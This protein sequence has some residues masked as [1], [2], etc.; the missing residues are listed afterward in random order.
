MFS[1]LLPTGHFVKIAWRSLLKNKSASIINL[2]GLS[3]G[4]TCCL[5]MVMYIQHEL[6]Y[7]RFQTKGERIA[8]VIMQ[9]SFGGSELT[10]G[11]FT[12]T[13]VLPSFKKNF[14]EVVDGVRLSAL[15]RLVKNKD[16]TFDEKGFLYADS[17]FFEMFDFKLIR[18]DAKTVLNGVNQIVLT[19]SAAKKYFGD[20]DP[21]GKTLQI[22]SSHENHIV[23]GI[24]ADCPANSQLIFTMVAPFTTLVKNPQEES[25]FEANYTTYLLLRDKNSIGTLQQK[26]EPFMKSELKNETGVYINYQFEPY[27]S[28][29]LHSPY[30]ALTP[31]SNIRYIYIIGA[32][33]I[34]V[35][36]IAC[37]TYINLSTAR[38]IERA[39]E[40]GI[41][42]VSGAVKS[43]VFWQFITESA[44]ISLL[45]T[46]VSMGLLIFVIPYFN[47]LTDKQLIFSDALKPGILAVAALIIAVISLLAG[48]YPA[49]ILSNYEPIKV[50]KGAFKNTSSGALLRK[51]LIVFQF[52]ISLFLIASTIVIGRQL[53]Y[54]QNK[55]LGYDR[56]HIILTKIDQKMRDKMDLFKTELKTNS[57]ITSVSMGNFTPVHIPGGYVMYRGDQTSDQAINTRGNNID[58]DYIKTNGLNII[59]GTDLT[60]QDLLDANQE[61]YTKNYFHFIINETAAKKLGWT[62]QEAIGKKMFLGEGRPGEVRGVVADFNFASLHST[63]EPLVLFPSNW[64]T[65]MMI[66][67]SGNDLANTIS[68][69]QTKWKAL[70]P[71]RPFEY[72]FMDED[73]NNLYISEIRTGK[74]FKIFSGIALILACLGL[75]GLSSYSAKQKL[76]ELSIRK[77]LGAS[78]AGLFIMLSRTFVWLVLIAFAIAMP[79]SWIVMNTWLK[80]FAYRIDN[81]AWMYVLTGL[82]AVI[83]T[84]FTISFQ[85]IKAAIANPIHSLRSE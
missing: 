80:D 85:S 37:F 46:M 59:S 82:I 5:L 64:A 33:A 31:N 63:I 62:A 79:L 9:Y 35:L 70:A 67:V 84:L 72:H 1:N 27:T 26:I 76:K 60:R 20:E 69:L 71:H 56:T 53:H 18:G 25:Y 8:R 54:I 40:V 11:N 83:I 52:V 50:L 39:R 7:D 23:S 65:I 47:Q 77:V 15:D 75:F 73:F 51:S 32:I 3:T 29:H 24:A 30:N 44:M 57:A 6:S 41:R 19:Q 66:K 21:M 78:A 49:I 2:L 61:D 28:I 55:N 38:S 81:S 17:S 4:L 36:I 58:E 10:T 68:F 13:K 34:L 43:Q 16:I 14:P 42:K 12:S 22:G 74:V 48:S 45:A